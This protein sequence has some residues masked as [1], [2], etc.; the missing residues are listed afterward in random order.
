MKPCPKCGAQNDAGLLTC[1][2][3]GGD[4]PTEQEMQGDATGG[5]IPYKNPKALLAYY[6]GILSGVPLL[7]LPASVFAFVL[8]VMGLTLLWSIAIVAILFAVASEQGW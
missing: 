5:V 2:S 8:G 7:G 4:L 1:S 3:C 6:L